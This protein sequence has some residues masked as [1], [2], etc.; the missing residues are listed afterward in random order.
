MLKIFHK[1]NDIDKLLE[2]GNNVVFVS[3]GVSLFNR[4]IYNKEVFL[5][6][7]LIVGIGRYYSGYGDW[8]YGYDS[9]S[10]NQIEFYIDKNFKIKKILVSNPFSN[11]SHYKSDSKI[12]KKIEK[13]SEN[14]K[15]DSEFNCNNSDI[16]YWLKNLLNILPTNLPISQENILKYPHMLDFYVNES[17]K[18]IK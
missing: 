14:I 16:N 12:Y 1:K 11:T 4:N 10:I 8:G 3:N 15:I 7:Y 2:I 18:I 6:Q 13:I 5:N 9:A 17:N